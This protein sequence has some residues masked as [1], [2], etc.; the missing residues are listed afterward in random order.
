MARYVPCSPSS[1]PEGIR[2]EAKD[3]VLSNGQA[4]RFDLY[5]ED[6][7]MT[8]GRIR[9]GSWNQRPAGAW[10]FERY[11][12]GSDYSGGF[13]CRANYEAFLEEFPD[14]CEK[15]W[16]LETPG[17]YCTYGL[18]LH[19][20]RAPAEAWEFIVS[21]VDY[22]S[23]DDE[24]VSELELEAADDAWDS[25]GR[26][27]WIKLCAERFG[28]DADEPPSI[29]WFQHFHEALEASNEYWEPQ[30]ELREVYVDL[31]RC[32]AKA[33]DPMGAERIEPRGEQPQTA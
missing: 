25:W 1:V 33:D 3:A 16:A 9:Y 30:G 11:L 5:R 10:Y 27:D 26:T 18:L 21:L 24:R 14:C 20:E 28:F 7:A 4:S 19:V 17:G 8:V 29:D 32:I 15:R 13:V 12:S 22:P 23:L 2:F 31:S 6:E